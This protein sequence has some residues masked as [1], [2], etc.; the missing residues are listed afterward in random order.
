MTFTRRRWPHTVNPWPT[1]T[2]TTNVFVLLGDQDSIC[3]TLLRPR[4]QPTQSS[5]VSWR[6]SPH[7]EPVL[8]PAFQLPSVEAKLRHVPWQP[9]RDPRRQRVEL[10]LIWDLGEHLWPNWKPRGWEACRSCCKPFLIRFPISPGRL[11][12]DISH[13][14]SGFSWP[15]RLGTEQQNIKPNLLATV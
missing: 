8:S 15:T 11:S 12:K 6:H 2:F 13:C 9:C 3:Y 1:S 14:L 4:C 10:L 7:H 5:S